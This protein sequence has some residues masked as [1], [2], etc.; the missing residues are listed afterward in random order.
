MP[1]SKVQNI[2]YINTMDKQTIPYLPV[3]NARPC[4]I[5]TPILDCTLKKK[6]KGSRKQRK[7]L[8]KN[9]IKTS[10]FGNTQI[11]TTWWSLQNCCQ[12]MHRPWNDQFFRWTLLAVSHSKIMD[13]V[14]PSTAPS[15]MITQGTLCVR[16][17][18]SICEEL[19]LNWRFVLQILLSHFQSH[20]LS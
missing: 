12:L 4:I 16:E 6:K 20:E 13:T 3:Y 2:I 1:F 7:W 14:R 5:R 18:R 9:S 8:R 15:F 19:E 10:W 11:T 17:L